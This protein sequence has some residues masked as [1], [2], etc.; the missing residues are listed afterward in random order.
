MVEQVNLLE[1]PAPAVG[2][3]SLVYDLHS[4][5]HLGQKIWLLSL[6]V[7]VYI[8]WII[9][10]YLSVDVDTGLDTGVGP[11]TQHLASQP[12]QLLEGVGG[13]GGG[14]GCLLLLSASGF[15]LFLAS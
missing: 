13:Q 15:R 11:L 8:K 7:H 6:T 14:A 9:S 10:V 5:L 2:G 3:H 12:V 4:V 1:H